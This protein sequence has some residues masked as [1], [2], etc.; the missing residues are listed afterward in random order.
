MYSIHS[1]TGDAI[2]RVSRIGT[3][4]TGSLVTGSS[5]SY[6]LIV[7]PENSYTVSRRS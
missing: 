3:D 1:R 6:T 2:T 4:H 5:Y 7:L